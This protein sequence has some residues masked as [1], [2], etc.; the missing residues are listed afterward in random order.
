[1]THT[2]AQVCACNNPGEF[3]L[4]IRRALS[5][6]FLL[7]KGAKRVKLLL[8]HSGPWSDPTADITFNFIESVAAQLPSQP[9]DPRVR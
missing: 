5:F 7:Q 9:L 2:I 1:M 6:G 3:F 4:P 8:R